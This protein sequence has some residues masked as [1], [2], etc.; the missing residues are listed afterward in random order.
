MSA[1]KCLLQD[2]GPRVI[3]L[4]FKNNQVFAY[5]ELIQ[6]VSPLNCL[7]FYYEVIAT[8]CASYGDV[9]GTLHEKG[10]KL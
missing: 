5:L 9:L 6:S 8:D 4:D 3:R 1:A 2:M 10:G 7:F